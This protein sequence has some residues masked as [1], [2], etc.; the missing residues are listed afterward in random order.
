MGYELSKIKQ[1][2]LA[3]LAGKACWFSRGHP[4]GE[5]AYVPSTPTLFCDGASLLRHTSSCSMRETRDCV[6]RDGAPTIDLIDGDQ[7]IDK[8][9]E[10]G[11]GVKTE[12]IEKVIIDHGWFSSI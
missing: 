11:L 2:L 8:L 3:S 6:S 4:P 9:K 10:L 5:T 7:L 12:K 1:S